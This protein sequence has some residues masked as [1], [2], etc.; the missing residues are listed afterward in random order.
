MKILAISDRPPKAP[1]K[2]ILD[3]EDLDL[4]CVLGDLDLFGLSELE[5]VT[6]IPK[7]G[8]YGETCSGTYFEKLGI[9][10]LHLDTFKC[11]GLTFGGFRGSVGH[12]ENPSY[13]TYTQKESIQLLKDFPRVDVMITHTPP[14]GV[15]DDPS[16]PIC[17]GFKGLRDYVSEK[18]PQYL[19]H[20]H[21]SPPEEFI[22]RRLDETEIVYVHGEKIVRI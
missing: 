2:K 21:T 20:G 19:I 9:Q 13:M 6:R 11:K 22:V 12:K 5:F 1:I 17:A 15:N 16:D 18:K 14:Y 3:Y 10:D 7:I 8:V 4:I